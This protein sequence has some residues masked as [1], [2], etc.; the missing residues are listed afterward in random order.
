MFA[1]AAVEA[2]LLSWRDPFALSLSC[3]LNKDGCKSDCTAVKIQLY[4]VV[5]STKVVLQ[6]KRVK[7]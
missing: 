7:G 4:R 5:V 6:V 2:L 1:V 3:I